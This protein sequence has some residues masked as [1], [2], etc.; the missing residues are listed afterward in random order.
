M[1]APF[2]FFNR[3]RSDAERPKRETRREKRVFVY[4]A[5]YPSGG[6][7]RQ[8]RGAVAALA[9]AHSGASSPLYGPDADGLRHKMTAQIARPDILAAADLHIVVDR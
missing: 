4:V 8:V 2:L 5:P 3:E 6:H 9:P 1:P 7:A